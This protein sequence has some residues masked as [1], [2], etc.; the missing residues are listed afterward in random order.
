VLTLEVEGAKVGPR[1]DNDL[2]RSHVV[3]EVINDMEEHVGDLI[4]TITTEL[5]ERIEFSG[6]QAQKSIVVPRLHP[7]SWPC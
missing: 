6:K 1:G 4:G 7:A 5:K 2:L 3:S